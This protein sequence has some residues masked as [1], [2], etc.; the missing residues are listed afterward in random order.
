MGVFAALV[1]NVYVVW[2]NRTVSTLE[3][4]SEK[5]ADQIVYFSETVADQDK[6]RELSQEP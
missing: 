2:I 5:F 1:H 3:Y 6:D 4:E